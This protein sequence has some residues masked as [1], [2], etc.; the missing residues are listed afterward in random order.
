MWLC[1]GGPLNRR[2]WI[3]PLRRRRSRVVNPPN[4]E[5]AAAA[6]FLRHY[7]ERTRKPDET[8]EQAEARA[9]REPPSL[10]RLVTGDREPG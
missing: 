3:H 1:R 7:A 2:L 9:R 8:P 4:A 10:A 5:P 6:R